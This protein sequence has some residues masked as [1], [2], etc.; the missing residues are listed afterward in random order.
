MLEICLLKDEEANAFL[1]FLS[2]LPRKIRKPGLGH[3][4]VVKHLPIIW[5]IPGSVPSMTKEEKITW[6]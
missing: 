1:S 6:F 2:S 3:N 4:S 5:T